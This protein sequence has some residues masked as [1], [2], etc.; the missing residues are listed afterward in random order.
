MTSTYSSACRPPLRCTF[1]VFHPLLSLLIVSQYSTEGKIKEPN[2][3]AD[4]GQSVISAV[5]SYARGDM[6]G[7]MRSAMGLV[8]TATGH[9]NA[10]KAEQITK[11]TRTSAADVVRHI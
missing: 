7:V 4:A 3:L 1:T 8:K 9:N 2:L 6:G 11:A 10:Q 5:T